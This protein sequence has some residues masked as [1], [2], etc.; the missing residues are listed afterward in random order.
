M[1]ENNIVDLECGPNTI[2]DG[3]SDGTSFSTAFFVTGTQ[4][5]VEKN[6]RNRLNLE[7]KLQDIKI[8]VIKDTTTEEFIVDN[9]PS[10]IIQKFSGIRARS[11]GVQAVSQGKIDAMVSD[12]ILLRAEAQK[13]ELLATQYPLIPKTPL[14]CDRY[15]MIIK[16]K[17]SQWLDFVNSVVYS[18]ETVKLSQVW[19]GQLFDYNFK[20]ST[21]CSKFGKKIK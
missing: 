1:V 5:L 13:Q 17:D 16:G 10:A 15:G 2:R 6:N 19:L 3:I 4:L 18:S 9:Y 12:G 7:G 21:D 14:T 8:G 11:R 20:D